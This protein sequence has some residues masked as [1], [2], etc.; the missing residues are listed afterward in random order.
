M[1]GVASAQRRL[2]SEQQQLEKPDQRCE[3]LA[4]RLGLQILEQLDDEV[5]GGMALAIDQLFEGDSERLGDPA[6]LVDPDGPLAVFQ[7]RKI[8]GADPG[9]F[10]ESVLG[11]SP[12]GAGFGDSGSEVGSGEGRE[13]LGFMFH[14]KAEDA[15]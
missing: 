8:G 14:G 10:G 2:G 13:G 1:Q 12:A 7:A 11:P 4:R 5:V 9:A 15:M 3:N 6:S